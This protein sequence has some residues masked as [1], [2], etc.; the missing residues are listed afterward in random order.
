MRVFPELPLLRRE[1]TELSNRRR[2]Y[3]VRVIAA[4]ILL[5]VVF[6]AYLKAVSDREQML[7]RVGMVLGP[8]RYLGIGGGVFADITPTLFYT[9][10]ILL[11]ALCCASITSEKE[12]NT[13]G[14]LLLTKLSPGTIILEKFGSR[15]IPML[16][17]L[18]LTFPVLA[19]VYSLG[20]VDTNL[21]IGTIWLLLCECFLIAAISILCSAWF[22]TTVAAFIWSYV[23]IGMLLVMTL[24][25]RFTTFMPSAIWRS[26]FYDGD[27]NAWT[28]QTA[29]L[30]A[31]GM[32]APGT[33]SETSWLVIV[34]RT[35]PG[36][37]VT[38]LLLLTARMVVV[39]R[40]FV[41]QTSV[42]LKVFRVVDRFFKALNDRTTGGIE[43]IKDRETLP[44]G[45]PVAWREQNKKSLGKARYLFRILVVLEAPTLFICMV[46]ATLSAYSA[47]R[48]LYV[49]QSLIW[50]LSILVASVKGA[51]LFSSERSRQ[52]IEPLL[53]TPMTAVEML[54]Q[55]VAGM[56]RLLLVL[57]TPI[58]TVSLTHFLLHI[59]FQSVTLVGAVRPVSYLALSTVGTFILLYLC[60]WI[61]AGIG[62][63][64]HSQTRAVLTAVAVFGTWTVLPLVVSG[65]IRLESPARETIL[66]L[67]PYSVV[68]ANERFLA[69]AMF[70]S[71]W[72][73]RT[74]T[75]GQVWWMVTLPVYGVML[76]GIW[77]LIRWNAARLLNR[78]ESRGVRTALPASAHQPQV[79]MLEGSR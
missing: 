55:K 41:S 59:N 72:S 76:L 35:L 9:I 2:T 65:A 13:I 50:T 66:T 58:L 39:R 18:L 68:E 52:T 69:G 60:A 29:F 36:L 79:A 7:S 16:T 19:H 22:A 73:Q 34:F 67:S 74:D 63:K 70:F 10:Q 4:C 47:F 61:S 14:T 54:G 12:S 62:L 51:T 37:M 49:L 23:L 42:L 11:P 1:L 27:W 40:A 33:Q 20:G 43:V 53:A 77:L 28:A 25:L 24:S 15:L 30:Q 57:A 6:L 17:L 46:A 71:A 21:L 75:V 56:R 45:D 44:L 48:G 78:R 38:A 64:I 3:I 8:T 32:G 5:L 26:V 31:M